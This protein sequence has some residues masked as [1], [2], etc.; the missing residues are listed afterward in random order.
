MLSRLYQ[1]QMFQI[2]T[3]KERKLEITPTIRNFLIVQ[4][5]RF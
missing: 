5:K 3:I 2:R 1:K 4:K